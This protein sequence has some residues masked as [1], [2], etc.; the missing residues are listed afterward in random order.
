MQG[1]FKLALLELPE[2]LKV[3]L[4]EYRADSE[5]LILCS[6]QPAF[7]A[8][9]EFLNISDL[10]GLISFR[11]YQRD[12]LAD[13]L[14]GA[15][16]AVVHHYRL[17]LALHYDVVI[18]KL[19]ASGKQLLV[20]KLPTGLVAVQAIQLLQQAVILDLKSLPLLN[21]STSP[22]LSDLLLLGH[23]LLVSLRLLQLLKHLL[24]FYL[25]RLEVVLGR[26]PRVL[27]HLNL[28]L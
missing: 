4:L 26:L 8:Y 15:S 17:H 24:L 18:L 28:G 23:L 27:Q 16:L 14:E 21:L 13:V 7:Q 19:L 3:H 20:C 22:L 1:H 25:S 2:V 12:G 10:P 9:Q 11:V 5:T 6:V